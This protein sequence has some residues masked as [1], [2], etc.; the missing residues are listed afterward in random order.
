MVSPSRYTSDVGKPGS[1]F[2]VPTLMAVALLGLLWRWAVLRLKL[3]LR[4]VWNVEHHNSRQLAK[5][6]RQHIPFYVVYDLLLAG[7]LVLLFTV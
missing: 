5:I 6:A 2:P 1:E 4:T 7:F 3:A